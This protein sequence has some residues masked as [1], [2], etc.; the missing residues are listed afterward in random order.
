MGSYSINLTLTLS[1]TLTLDVYDMG[2][3]TSGT[4]QQPYYFAVVFPM[5]RHYLNL[6]P[7]PDYHQ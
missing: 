3:M 5:C 6:I 7:L 2:P 4:H 1:L